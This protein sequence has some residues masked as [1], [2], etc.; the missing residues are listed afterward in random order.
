M[1]L[2]SLGHNHFY[3][4]AMIKFFFVVALSFLF[5]LSTA[6]QSV[7]EAEA[8]FNGGRYA[9]A[10]EVYSLLMAQ[11]RRD[12]MLQYKAAR[13]LVAIQRYDEAIPLLG[14]AAGKKIKKAWYYLYEAF[15]YTYRFDQ[16]VEALETY[17]HEARLTGE[18]LAAAQQL[19]GQAGSALKLYETVEAVAIVDS[20][21]ILKTNLLDAYHLQDMLGSVFYRRNDSVQSVGYMTGRGDKKIISLEQDSSLSLSVAYKLLGSWGDTVRLSSNVN[22]GYDENYP[23]ELTDGITLY[24]ASKGHGSLGGYDIFMTR[25][26]SAAN[27]YT[28]PLNIGMPFN[29][30]AN[31]Y[32]LVL[33]ELAGRGWF[34]TDRFQHPDSVVVYCFVPNAERRIVDDADEERH[35]RAAMLLEYDRTD[36]AE[37]QHGPASVA[38]EEENDRQDIC[39]FVND[40]LVYTSVSQFRSPMA[41]QLYSALQ[42]LYKRI[43]TLGILLN[44][45]RRE[46]TFATDEADKVVLR[47]EVL[48]LEDDLSA[49]AVEVQTTLR[50]I[51]TLEIGMLSS[52]AQ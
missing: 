26:N 27:D 44:G 28:H 37:M 19:L 42:D 17:I 50:S 7:K 6:G 8:L 22:T 9:D 16:A 5:T 10:Y 29:S 38:V 40:G 20:V 11:N 4:V 45:K 12:A 35:R 49:L 30:P 32:M 36:I 31:D 47:A 52:G 1:G 39:F 46:Y 13:C 25:F 34:A 43:R 2:V 41:L 48:G 51:R 3:I 15:Y 23:F 33:D 24:F 14:F 21:R 18:S